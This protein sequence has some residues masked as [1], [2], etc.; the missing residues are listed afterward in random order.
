MRGIIGGV[1]GK[2]RKEG[3]AHYSKI[4]TFIKIR[5]KESNMKYDRII[6]IDPDAR[7]SGVAQVDIQ[8]KDI[9]TF[10]MTFAEVI[11]YITVIQ[12]LA[13]AE[14]WRYKV[15][16]E[17]GWLNDSNWHLK[18]KYMSAR[19]AADIGRRVGMNHQTG[20]L[21]YEVCKQ[22]LGCDTEL[23]KPLKKC[24]KGKDGKITQEEMTEVT[25]K[26]KLP[27]MNQDQRDAL[28]I[29]W[30]HAGLPIRIKPKKTL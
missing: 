3:Y 14:G 22:Y 1:K 26:E 8:I 23:Q 6:A 28:L 9:A 30:V 11:S 17:A 29:A 18:G 24:W 21:L 12:K 4:F 16:I 19:K 25:E 13:V 20:V 5:K 27:R 2:R 10:K 7:E 15:V